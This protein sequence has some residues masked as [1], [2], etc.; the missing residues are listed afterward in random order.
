MR[1]ISIDIFGKTSDGRPCAFGDAN[2]KDKRTLKGYKYAGIEG[3][4][5]IYYNPKNLS[6]KA[7][8]L[9]AKLMLQAEK[10]KKG[11]KK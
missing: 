5:M 11:D 2:V 9:V 7:A 8:L 3:G 6:L 1:I 10:E 4:C